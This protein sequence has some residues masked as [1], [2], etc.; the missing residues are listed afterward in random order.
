MAEKMNHGV[1]TILESALY[2]HKEKWLFRSLS[3]PPTS[4]RWVFYSTIFYSTHAPPCDK[5]GTLLI[6]TG[7][8]QNDIK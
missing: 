5:N 1:N 6:L 7:E 3:P 8:V 4:N 2:L